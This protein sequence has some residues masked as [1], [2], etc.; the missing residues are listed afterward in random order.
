MQIVDQQK[1]FLYFCY[2]VDKCVTKL[3]LP[4]MKIH[5]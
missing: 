2:H 4:C 5:F 3:D 1:K